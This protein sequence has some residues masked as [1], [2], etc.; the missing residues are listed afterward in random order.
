MQDFICECN[1]TYI[2]VNVLLISVSVKSFR[3]GEKNTYWTF[4]T[5][6]MRGLLIRDQPW[7]GHLT[8]FILQG[9]QGES[10]LNSAGE[11]NLWPSEQAYGHCLYLTDRV[12]KTLQIREISWGKTEPWKYFIHTDYTITAKAWHISIGCKWCGHVLCSVGTKQRTCRMK[13]LFKSYSKTSH[14][15]YKTRENYAFYG[16][17]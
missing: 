2:L 5:L 3:S 15:I 8:W 16:L 14:L 11:R 4:N 9:S 17:L 13:N 1:I 6:Q 12:N 10:Q 7:K